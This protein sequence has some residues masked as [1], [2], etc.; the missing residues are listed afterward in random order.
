MSLT[1]LIDH[2]IVLF[3]A[4][5]LVFL[6]TVEAGHRLG[7]W[8][9]TEEDAE[10]QEQ[11]VAA[12]DGTT[13]L[14]SLLLGFTLAMGLTNYDLRKRLITAEANSIGTTM[15]R[16]QMLPEPAR[17]RIEDLLRQ[18]VEERLALVNAGLREKA[19]RVSDTRA[20]QLQS[21]MWEQTRA[22]VQQNN[23]PV[24]AL[25]VQA[26]NETIDFSET[27]LSALENRI[28]QGIWFMLIFVSLLA[29]LLIGRSM[30]KK[31]VLLMLVTPLMFAVVL[32]LIADL[33]SPRTGLIQVR[34]ASMERL[35]AP[36]PVQVPEP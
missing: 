7:L 21:E 12:R 31:F 35:R 18:Y 4:L 30:R 27:Q 14:L 33:D 5:F 26:L 19:F 3:L 16:A 6:I 25:F 15:L 9:S 8:L 32:A 28:P 24:T 1:S 2:P 17:G 34:Q 22:I 11:V 20:R 10:R 23:N 36:L 13:L 29:S